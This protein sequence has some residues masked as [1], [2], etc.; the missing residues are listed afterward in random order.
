MDPKLRERIVQGAEAVFYA[1][2][3]GAAVAVYA[4]L[5]DNHFDPFTHDGRIHLTRLAI[6]AGLGS[7]L[8][9]FKRPHRNPDAHSDRL[10]DQA[11]QPRVEDHV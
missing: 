3:S 2:L 5:Q 8:A 10:E 4:A 1:F 7:I 9:Y 6:T 11:G